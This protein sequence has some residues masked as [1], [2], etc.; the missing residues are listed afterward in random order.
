MPS[1]KWS[2]LWAVE[3]AGLY[4]SYIACLNSKAWSEVGNFV[5]SEITHNGRPLGV[6]GYRD[7]L[8]AD[9]EA[10]PDLRFNIDLLVTD[11]RRVAVRLLFDCTP[12]GEFLGLPVHG[13]RV[14]FA[15][16]AFYAYSNDKIVSV[17]SIIDKGAIEAQITNA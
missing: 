10:I 5:D 6:E 2:E 1:P 4:R 3:L 15:E 11:A 13:R 12:K 8:I 7:M 17:R 16:H 9:Y 14:T